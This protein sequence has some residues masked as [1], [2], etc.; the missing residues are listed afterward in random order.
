VEP[1]RLFAW[2]SSVAFAGLALLA[3]EPAWRHFHQERAAARSGA[4]VIPW[5]APPA[6][7]VKASLLRLANL[8]TRLGAPKPTAPPPG[9]SAAPDEPVSREDIENQWS[10]ESREAPWADRTEARV[11]ELLESHALAQAIPD[12]A[13]CKSSLCKLEGA[14]ILT[15]DIGQLASVQRELDLQVWIFTEH[16]GRGE[17]PVFYLTRDDQPTIRPTPEERDS[18]NVY[19]GSNPA[20]SAENP[21]R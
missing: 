17:H 1:L 6:A 5:S 2:T 13:R 11:R 20:L 15:A 14:S 7:S 8:G 19:P 9:A 18:R 4:G 10:A 3:V 21:P 12:G 16:D